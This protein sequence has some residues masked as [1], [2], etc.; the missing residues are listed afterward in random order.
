MTLDGARNF[1]LTIA[2]DGTLFLGWQRQAIGPTIQQTLEDALAKLCGHEITVFASGRTDTGVHAQAQ[3]VNFFTSS[4]RTP[5]E[6]VKGGNAILPKTIAI[7]S[8]QE[9]PEDFNARYSA[10]GK[11]YA[12]YYYAAKIRDPLLITRAWHV[13]PNLD[14]ALMEENLSHLIGSRDF[15]SLASKGS[16]TK[17]TIRTIWQA[18]ITSREENIKKLTITGS[19]FLRHMV[20]TIA[21]TLHLIGRKRLSPDYLNLVLDSLDRAKAGPVAPPHGLYLE[22]VFY[23]PFSGQN[24]AP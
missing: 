20:R 23:Q 15:K 21:G 19:G 22:K 6:L 18:H 12:Y 16:E 8:A 9:A 3:V 14:W 2:Y 11:T 1:K 7:L 10:K 5:S 17:S 24:D 4:S 13:G